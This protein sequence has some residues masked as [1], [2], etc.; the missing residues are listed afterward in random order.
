MIGSYDTSCQYCVSL[1]FSS[2]SRSFSSHC[3]HEQE[4]GMSFFGSVCICND[5]WPYS[6]ALSTKD[7]NGFMVLV[8]FGGGSIHLFLNSSPGKSRFSLG[9]G[10]PSPHVTL[11][12]S[13]Y[14][15]WAC[16]VR[17]H[18]SGRHWQFYIV[19]KAG[20]AGSEG[21]PCENLAEE[22]GKEFSTLSAV[23]CSLA[24][25]SWESMSPCVGSRELGTVF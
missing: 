25:R 15:S 2:W 20:E 13:C 18:Y 24:L 8:Q 11:A 9:A 21:L 17:T 1:S 22:Q 19:L 6:S 10:Q 12:S 4:Q 3:W 23:L 5:L 14:L 7:K 16:W